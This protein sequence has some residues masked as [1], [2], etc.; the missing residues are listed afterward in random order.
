MNKEHIVSRHTMQVK[1]DESN[2]QEQ[3]VR[4]LDELPEPRIL[5]S[6]IVIR[7]K[8]LVTGGLKSYSVDM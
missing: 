2:E 6:A 4:I 1:Y 5:H 8:L 3:Y 7:D